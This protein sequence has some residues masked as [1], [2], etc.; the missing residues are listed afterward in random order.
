MKMI[1][2]LNHIMI[3]LAKGY[4][5]SPLALI[6]M[7]DKNEAR[8]MAAECWGIDKSEINVFDYSEK[9]MSFG[10]KFY[11]DNDEE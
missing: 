7:R 2:A 11:W 1:T 6:G 3:A 8:K 10:I 9:P 5:H 4:K